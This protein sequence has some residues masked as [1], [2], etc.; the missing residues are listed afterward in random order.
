MKEVNKTWQMS[1]KY[2]NLVLEINVKCSIVKV[3]VN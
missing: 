2:I 1:T 3:K